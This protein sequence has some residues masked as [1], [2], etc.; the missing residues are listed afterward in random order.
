M[1]SF[2]TSCGH[3]V[4]VIPVRS[5]GGTQE[6]RWQVRVSGPSINLHC[7][8]K[9]L[10]ADTNSTAVVEVVAEYLGVQVSGLR[11]PLARPRLLVGFD[12]ETSNWDASCSF[13]AM[14]DHFDAGYPCQADHTSGAGFVCGLG[15]S[16]FRATHDGSSMYDVDQI[17]SSVI[18][19]PAGHS[20]SQKAVNVHGITDAIC[21]EGQELS[22][23]L[24]PVIVL[25]KEGAEI[26]CHNL[27]HETLVI[28]RELQK[29]SRIGAPVLSAQ[30]AALLLRSLY[31]G[32]CTSI[33]A[34]YRNNGHYRRLSD[35]FQYY[36]G[37]STITDRQHDPGWDAYKCGRLLLHYNQ[38][39][40]TTT[41]H[42][43]TA[44]LQSK[45]AKL[46]TS[47]I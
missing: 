15:F 16:V 11:K 19:L 46:S 21:H 14:S 23:A 8:F 37:E 25:L 9:C 41:T 31:T 6:G 1:Q 36:F 29:R 22:E 12:V 33:L 44:L 40:L 10:Y 7:G 39:A 17:V 24:R 2:E 34:K 4:K 20:I 18:K 27:R 5:C 13:K 32:H 42:C 38:A 43:E 35:E 47:S 3:F 45:R 28:C 30:D 26:C